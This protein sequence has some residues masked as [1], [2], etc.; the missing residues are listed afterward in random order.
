MCAQILYAL[1][2]FPGSSINYDQCSS[3]AVQFIVEEKIMTRYDVE[4]LLAVGLEG[5]FG[6]ITV[7]AIMSLLSVPSISV[8]SIYF[9]V[10]RGWHQL[11]DNPL[12]LWSAVAIAISVSVFDVCGM[13][14]THRV[15]ATVRTLTDSCR[16]LVIWILSLGL[17]WEVLMW[18]FSILQVLGFGLLV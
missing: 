7:L 9:D 3:T 2:S 17:G 18:P 10:S 13:G 15:S 16:T 11:I 6:F 8:K 5:T 12:V 4:P 1:S 14:I